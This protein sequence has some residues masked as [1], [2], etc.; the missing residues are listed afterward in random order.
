[1]YRM[2]NVVI[3]LAAGLLGSFLSRH[4]TPAPV[5]AQT[6]TSAPIAIQARSFVLVDES[7]N[8]I[9][10]FKP[11]AIKPSS[12]TATVVLL[13]GNGREIWRAGIATQ[14]LNR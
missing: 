9:G 10:T 8:V 11:S 14:L 5:L 3:A 12:P 6:R 4:I 2:L 7:N 1:M 13:D